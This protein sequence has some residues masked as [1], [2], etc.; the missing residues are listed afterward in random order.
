MVNM[1]LDSSEYQTTIYHCTCNKL[2][3]NL[4]GEIVLMFPVSQMI[5]YEKIKIDLRRSII[6][7]RDRMM[8]MP[9]LPLVIPR[10]RR[11]ESVNQRSDIQ[12]SMVVH[13]YHMRWLG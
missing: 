4:T 12:C 10:S 6:L 8:G 9:G 11:P 5:N 13:H 2:Y 3:T 1:S 7:R